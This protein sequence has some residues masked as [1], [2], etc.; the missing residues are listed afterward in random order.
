MP[1]QM[2]HNLIDLDTTG[3]SGATKSSGLDLQPIKLAPLTSDGS[4]SSSGT[5]YHSNLHAKLTPKASLW[6]EMDSVQVLAS[7]NG[8]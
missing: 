2:L 3:L 1:L 7:C 4:N 8:R 5:S 6:L